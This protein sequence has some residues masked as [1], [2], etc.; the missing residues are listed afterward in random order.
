MKNEYKK[1]KG[2]KVV[3]LPL[4]KLPHK[5]NWYNYHHYL[6]VPFCWLHKECKGICSDWMKK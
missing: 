2:N 1:Q 6:Q 5:C 4:P 3:K